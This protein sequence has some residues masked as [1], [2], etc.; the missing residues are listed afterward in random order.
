M[1]QLLL[2]W[3]LCGSAVTFSMDQKYKMNQKYK[4]NYSIALAVFN[5]YEQRE[6][7]TKNIKSSDEVAV[8]NKEIYGEIKKNSRTLV[9]SF[10]FPSREKQYA[11]YRLTTY[12]DQRTNGKVI[13]TLDYN[14]KAKKNDSCAAPYFVKL[15]NDIND[16]K[17]KNLEI[18]KKILHEKTIS[19]NENA[20]RLDCLF[21]QVLDECPV[22]VFPNA[23]WE[24]KEKNMINPIYLLSQ[25]KNG[26]KLKHY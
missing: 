18:V 12:N 19:K 3:L 15:E 2:L 4:K 21:T 26:Y 9:T 20:K 10:P 23:Y 25:E 24:K 14:E 16:F 7:T 1:K 6:L 5:T 17:E 22:I 11:E 13:F 8:E